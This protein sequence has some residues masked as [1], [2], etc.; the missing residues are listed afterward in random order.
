MPWT[1]T[2]LDARARDGKFVFS[3]VYSDGQSKA[4]QDY[5]VSAISVGVVRQTARQQV[6]AYEAAGASTGELPKLGIGQPIDVTLDPPVVPDPAVVARNAF[7]ALWQQ[8]RG[9]MGAD[10]ATAAMLV[11]LQKDFLD[12]YTDGMG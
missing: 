9:R 11:T 4:M 6:A 8:Y 7:L 12:A 2:L 5:T 3:I 1:A 10:A